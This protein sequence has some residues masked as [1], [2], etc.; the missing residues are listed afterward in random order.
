[1]PDQAEVFLEA[2]SLHK[3]YGRGA[4]AFEA[5]KGVSLSIKEG[6]SLAILGKSG[7]GK[8]TLMHLLAGLDQPTTGSICYQG[9]SLSNMN[10]GQLSEFRNHN[11]GFIFQQF[12][13]QPTL[14]V[15]ENVILPLKIAGESGEYRE[16]QAKDALSKVGLSDKVKNR[17]TDLSGGQKQRVAIARALVGNPKILFADEPTGNLDTETASEVIEL[18]QS[19]NHQA[20]IILVVVTHDPD[21]AKQ[22]RRQIHIKDGTVQ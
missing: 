9:E 7:S 13:L 20:G 14:T 19:L 3:T 2:Q 11:V 4:A 8:S 15:L 6:D 17:A 16:K 1:M 18:L 10:E 21:L 5:L 22:C 12:F